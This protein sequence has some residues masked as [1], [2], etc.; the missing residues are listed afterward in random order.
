MPSKT[1]RPGEQ[2]G[3]PSKRYRRHIADLIPDAEERET[4]LSGAKPA[5]K[6]ESRRGHLRR[7][8]KP[9]VY[10]VQAEALGLIKIGLTRDAVDRLKTLQVGSPDKLKLLG[11]IVHDDAE[12][13]EHEAHIAFKDL[14]SHGEWFRPDARLLEFIARFAS[15]LVPVIDYPTRRNMAIRAKAVEAESPH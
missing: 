15:E 1:R 6:G 10:F 2:R 9:M 13:I 12:E 4:Y 5:Q 8:V 14:H 3:V 7:F 11:V